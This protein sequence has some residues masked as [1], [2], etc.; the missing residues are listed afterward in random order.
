MRARGT[1]WTLLGGLL[2][3]AGCGDAAPEPDAM[4]DMGEMEETSEMDDPGPAM[5]LAGPKSVFFE[6]PA[7]GA[8]VGPDFTVVLGT[9]NLEIVE[10]GV[11]DPDTGHH[12]IFVDTDPTPM[13]EVIPANVPEVIHMGDGSFEYSFEGMEPGE[14]RLIAVVGDGAHIPLEP[15]VMDTLTVT[16]VEP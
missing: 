9:E 2:V 16:V 3:L 5:G 1:F 11:F 7:E 14:H 12:H 8:E 10:S 4:D 13:G 6:E 15:P